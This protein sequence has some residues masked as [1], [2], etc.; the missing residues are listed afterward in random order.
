[1]TTDKS[2]IESGIKQVG[3]IVEHYRIELFIAQS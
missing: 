3:G 2:E 1:M